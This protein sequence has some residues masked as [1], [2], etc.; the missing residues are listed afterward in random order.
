MEN[1][2]VMQRAK[3]DILNAI[4]LKRVICNRKQRLPG[5]LMEIET[6]DFFIVW[7]KEESED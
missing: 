2:E 6:P 1:R 5:F 7:L 4:I 3:A